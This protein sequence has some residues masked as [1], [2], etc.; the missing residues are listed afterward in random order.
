MRFVSHI[1]KRNTNNGAAT[2]WYLGR[3]RRRCGCGQCLNKETIVF[4]FLFTANMFICAIHRQQRCIYA[5]LLSGR[6]REWCRSFI[7]IR[8]IAA[9]YRAAAGAAYFFDKLRFVIQLKPFQFRLEGASFS[10]ILLALWLMCYQW[11]H[12]VAIKETFVHRNRK[13]K[14]TSLCKTGGNDKFCML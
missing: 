14:V 10:Y 12:Y 4:F 7:G 6:L 5:V 1:V 13:H 9:T 11:N 8:G 2:E 3:V